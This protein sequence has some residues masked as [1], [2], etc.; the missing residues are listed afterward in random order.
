MNEQ[1]RTW[2]LGS[3]LRGRWYMVSKL[4]DNWFRGRMLNSGQYE[5]KF[6]RR[7]GCMPNYDNPQ[8][9]PDKLAWM[10]LYDHNPTYIQLVDKIAVRDY[11]RERVGDDVLL[12]HYGVWDRAGDIDFDSLPDSFVL[13]CNHESGFVIL[14]PDK[15]QLDKTFA[16]LQ[17]ATRLRMNYYHRFGEWAYQFVKPRVIAEKLLTGEDGGEPLDYKIHCFEGVPHF[18]WAI[19]N[20]HSDRVAANYTPDWERLPFHGKSAPLPGNL[21]RPATLEQ[22][23]E[24]AKALSKGLPYCRVDLYSVEDRVYFGE[25]TIIHGAG[26]IGYTP[27]EWNLRWGKCLTLPPKRV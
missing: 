1:A 6:F 24:M 17:L 10:R 12:P 9:L 16:R 26:L 3:E 4:T 11:V 19:K 21:P 5:R 14:C 2:R 15:S 22:M 25:M 18:V 20:R 7:L 27:E 13:K 23:L 8:T